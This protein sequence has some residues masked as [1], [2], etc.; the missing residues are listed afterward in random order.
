MK[1]FIGSGLT[2]NAEE[3]YKEI[4]KAILMAFLG[5][6]LVS[7]SVYLSYLGLHVLPFVFFGLSCFFFLRARYFGLKRLF[8]EEGKN[9]E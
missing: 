5:G 9:G 2:R 6:A 1:N 7:F 4:D 3:H 8:G